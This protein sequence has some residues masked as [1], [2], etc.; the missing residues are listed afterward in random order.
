[1]SASKEVNVDIQGVWKEH[2]TVSSL[3]PLFYD[4]IKKNSL[5]FIGMNPSFNANAIEK[6]ASGKI[7]TKKASIDIVDDLEIG[8]VEKYFSNDNDNFDIKKALIID[9][10]ARL[11]Y[12]YFDKFKELAK[13]ANL[14]W[15]HIDLFFV[16]ETS[17]KGFL[18]KMIDKN[19]INEFGKEQLRLSRRLIESSNPQF[20]IVANAKASEIF[21]K[22]YGSIFEEKLGC[23]LTKING[24]NVPTMCSSMLTG[25]RALDR[26]SY[27]SM[28]WNMK[29]I[30]KEMAD[31]N[32]NT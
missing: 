29:R 28:E 11:R 24:K 3:Q 1:M 22:E 16:R 17:Q 8:D 25:Q 18:S 12:S 27:Q 21:I 10:R 31:K 20:I 13:A 5:L 4:E 15:D 26:Y 7:G 32:K 30:I 14:Q 2:P 23:Y 6:L 9:A 19:E